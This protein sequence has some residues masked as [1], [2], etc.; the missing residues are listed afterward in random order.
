ML[1]ILD[2]LPYTYISGTGAMAEVSTIVSVIVEEHAQ[3]K[4]AEN[5]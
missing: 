5:T 4:T 2:H 1:E 3:T